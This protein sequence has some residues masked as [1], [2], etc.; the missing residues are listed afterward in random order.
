VLEGLMVDHVTP[1]LVLGGL[2]E[3]AGTRQGDS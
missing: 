1:L 3:G 2:L